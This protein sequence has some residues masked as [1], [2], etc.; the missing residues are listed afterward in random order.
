MMLQ[1]TNHIF[2][3]MSS[4]ETDP[5]AGWANTLIDR[6]FGSHVAGRRTRLT[7]TRSLLDED[8]PHLGGSTGFL[9]A[10]KRG[11]L[12]L[13]APGVG[14]ANFHNHALRLYWRW[15]QPPG[16]RPAACFCLPDNAPLYLPHLAALSLAWTINPDE[17]ELAANAFYQRLSVILPD[18]GLDPA[19]LA[20]WRKL[21]DGLEKWTAELG[22]KRGVFKVEVLGYF[23]HVGIPL[24]QVLLTPSKV[25]NLAE[26][27]VSTGLADSWKD[28]D[29]ARLRRVLVAY[30]GRTRAAL[31]G[32]LFKEIQNVGSAIGKATVERL[33]E[34]LADPAFR[35][36]LSPEESPIEIQGSGAVV[37]RR[38]VRVRLVLESIDQPAGWNCRFGVLASDQ[39]SVASRNAGWTFSKVDERLG[40]LW[41]ATN[42]HS[43]KGPIDATQWA[44]SLMEGLSIN[45]EPIAGNDEEATSLHLPARK[46][47][48][49]H[50][51]NWVGQRLVEEDAL[52]TS[53]GC[54]IMVSPDTRSEAR[55]WMETFKTRGGTISDFTLIG[56]PDSTSLF[57]LSGMEHA[58]AE[59]LG[60]FP[61]R[62]IARAESRACIYL[63]G[64]S[65]VH[66]TGNQQVYLP[67]DPPDV[68]LLAPSYVMLET[69]GAK[70]VDD[71]TSGGPWKF[72]DG[73][74]GLETRQ[75][76]LEVE[77]EAGQV[78]VAA[79]ASDE[80]WIPQVV[81]FGVGREA[82][83]GADFA[84]DAKVRFD[85]LGKRT[86]GDGILGSS[87]DAGVWNNEPIIQRWNFEECDL[88]MGEPATPTHADH[89]GWCLLES[90]AQVRRV[91]AQEFRRRCERILNW[92]PR[93][94]WSEARWIRA[95]CH[96]E[97]ERDNRGRI[98]YV[99]AVPPHAYLLPWVNLGRWLA[100]VG[101]CP[102]REALRRLLAAAD[103]MDVKVSCS[104]RQSPLLP[105]RWICHAEDLV[106]IELALEEAGIPLAT[107][108][109]APRPLCVE[110]VEW[111]ASLDQWWENLHW[112][113]GQSPVR[114]KIFNPR[115][116]QMATNESFACPYKL[117][118]IT[119][120]ITQKHQWHMLDHNGGWN[121]EPRHAFLFDP[122]WGKWLS[123]SKIVSEFPETTHEVDQMLTPLP[124]ELEGH[125]L[126]VPASLT[127][128]TMLSRALLTS[129]G[130][131]PVTLVEGS[132]HYRHQ[133][134]LFIPIDQ[135]P[136]TGACHR[137]ND[138][139]PHV[140]RIACNKVSAQIVKI[141]HT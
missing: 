126:H 55:A 134:S 95:L 17:E 60:G 3:A 106:A 16:Q 76:R 63:R 13:S 93:Y 39:P 9:N 129:S 58:D 78:R 121:G 138:I 36:W 53:G 90:L 84:E 127:F 136:Y 68:V 41:L 101:G 74:P 91:T 112:L 72:P 102:T 123:M 65:Q 140:A 34:F 110:V 88:E 46:I 30:E 51:S 108:V 73:M 49:F 79:I 109:N 80:S 23:V 75:F 135:P 38:I 137:Y 5:Y 124:F 113:E 97:V 139:H 44:A 2:A 56:L 70:L 25:S 10:V 37:I 117:I 26:L 104:E 11:P 12:S 133:Q 92:W 33:L 7:V 27:F 100:V 28:V 8:Y 43:G 20:K 32:M 119:D 83:L 69:T 128:P 82:A 6:F 115:H 71:V 1:T 57:H 14:A 111:A 131:P 64:G 81:T 105:P 24:S 130:M 85:P 42:E 62:Q 15:L 132:P 66:G 118:S 86:N 52:P 125:S 61:E 99:Y 54:F 114:E 29:E 141:N 47:R 31:G 19:H 103:L 67:Y 94:A 45:S 116:F 87:I 18:H 59:L 77:P 40:G 122:S 50:D 98:A 120:S 89:L 4:Q 107:D 35:E 48:V 96:V 22:G 21:W